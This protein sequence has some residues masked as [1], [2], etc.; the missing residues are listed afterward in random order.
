MNS[1]NSLYTVLIFVFTY[2]QTGAFGES[3]QQRPNIVLILTDDHPW[4]AYGFMGDTIAHTPHIDRFSEQALI[5]PFGYVTAPV[6]RPS[7]GTVLTG[8]YPHQSKI[9]FNQHPEH[10]RPVSK[11]PDQKNISNASDIVTKLETLP[12]LLRRAGYVSLQTGKHWEGDFRDAG[13][14]EG[15]AYY[16]P[17][18]SKNSYNGTLRE[19]KIGRETM[20]PIYRFVNTQLEAE[21]PF[22]IWYAPY[23]P[24]APTNAPEKFRKP[25]YNKNLEPYELDYYAN[26]TWLDESV[27]EL[28]EFF[29][30]KELMDNTVFLL[31]TDNGMTIHPNPWW[32]GLKGKSSVW[33]MGIRTPLLVKWGNK[34]TQSVCNIPVSSVDVVPTFLECA[35]IDYSD[36]Q[37]P[38]R[39]IIDVGMDCSTSDVVPVFGEVYNPNPKVNDITE[40]TVSY[41]Y[42]IMGDYKLI[43]PEN[44]SDRLWLH[45]GWP[46]YRPEDHFTNVRLFNIKRDPNELVNLAEFGEYDK[47]RDEMIA[48]L[49]EWWPVNK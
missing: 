47:K 36:V 41:R 18:G 13:F 32:G 39:N 30:E 20:E 44:I 9:W 40:K 43:S 49:N 23:I 42:V 6:C 45:D 25:Y 14:D 38:G 19:N 37:L 26:I 12:D 10:K 11:F 27:G 31:L 3:I 7:L 21:N 29:E 22:F 1:K 17:D 46:G 33:Q 8:L 28:L 16:N 48:V 24:H 5:F 2:L 35:G 4:N 15:T 34:L